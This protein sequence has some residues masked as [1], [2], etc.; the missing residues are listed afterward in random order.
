[1]HSMVR[2]HEFTHLFSIRILTSLVVLL[3]V[4]RAVPTSVA[5][6][7]GVGLAYGLVILAWDGEVRRLLVAPVWNRISVLLHRRGSGAHRDDLSTTAN[8]EKKQQ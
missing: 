4:S 8:E 1:M 5:T 7:A 3:A 6:I 2:L